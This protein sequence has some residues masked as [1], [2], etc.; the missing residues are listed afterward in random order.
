MVIPHPIPYQG[1][2]RRI[3]HKILDFFPPD[4]KRLVEPFA[5]SAAVT[6]AAAYHGKATTFLINDLNEPLMR[7][8]REIILRPSRIADEYENLWHAQ[9]GRE[10]EYYDV[11]RTR[12]NRTHEPHFLLYLLARCVKASVR[13]NS[14]GEFNQ[15]PDNRRK[16]RKPSAMRKDIIAVSRLL[17]GRVEIRSVDF[18][19]ILERMT[20]ADLVYMDPPYQGVCRDRDPRYLKGVEFHRF[21]DCLGMLNENSA[22]YIVSYDGLTG[23][24]RHGRNLPASIGLLHMMIDAGTSS[25]STLLGR[26]E[27]TIESIYLSPSLSARLGNVSVTQN[28]KSSEQTTL[29]DFV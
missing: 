17:K 16:G 3:A 18:T 9:L 20:S 25:Q 29:E 19:E 14:K 12:F 27:R 11:V 8:W 2:K 28:I 13:Y 7:L 21:V 23:A 24:K 15:A 6:I 5:G 22:Q 4:T 26:S 1:S 10:R